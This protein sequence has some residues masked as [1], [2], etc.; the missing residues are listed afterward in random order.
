MTR[1][2]GRRTS[3]SKAGREITSPLEQSLG[4]AI[5]RLRDEHHVSVRALASKCG[6]SPSFIS[7]V[8]LNQASPSLSSLERI[9]HGLGVTLGQ[10]F[11]ASEP[12]T[13]TV[14]R[15]SQRPKIQSGW[16]RSQIESLS[17]QGMGSRLEAL[18]ITM[19]RGGSSGGRLHS[20]ETEL[21]AI[22]FTGEVWL[23][24]RETTQILRRG[25]AITIPPGTLHRWENKAAKPV[26]LVKVIH[27]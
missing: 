6:F 24:L 17:L 21:F 15:A 16:S 9:A 22:V 18:L 12:A 4:A 7:Q 10:F 3:L 26:Q 5:H 11:L 19:R 20:R 13:P 8:E 1:Q 2:G 27:V 23:Q 14:I 25:D